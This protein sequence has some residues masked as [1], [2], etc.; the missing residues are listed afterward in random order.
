MNF[1]ERKVHTQRLRNITGNNVHDMLPSLTRGHTETRMRLMMND[2]FKCRIYDLH[3]S[4]ETT[5]PGYRSATAAAVPRDDLTSHN[6][7]PFSVPS[8]FHKFRLQNDLL[9]HFMCPSG[10]L[11]TYQLGSSSMYIYTVL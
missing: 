9:C 4:R 3:V 6:Q 7:I 11:N 1:G 10:A 5:E 2:Q 8:C